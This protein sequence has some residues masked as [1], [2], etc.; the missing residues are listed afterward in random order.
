MRI[1]QNM[2]VH[3]VTRNLNDTRVKMDDLNEQI[4]SGKRIRKPSDDPTGAAVA[5]GLRARQ[6]RLEAQERGRGAAKDWLESTESNLADL[7]NTLIRVKELSVQAANT[8][9]DQA[10]RGHIA[11]ELDQILDHL[12]QVGNAR[13]GD[14]FLFAGDRTDTPPFTRAPGPAGATYNGTTNGVAMRV[15]A[16]VVIDV[17]IT[18]DRLLSVFSAIGALSTDLQTPGQEIDPVRLQAIEDAHDDVLSARASTGAKMNRLEALGE[19]AAEEGLAIAG[20]LSEVEDTDFVEAVL[21][22]QT[23]Q[24]VYQAALATGAKVIQPSLLDFLR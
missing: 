16:G 9:L 4:T 6:A 23:R 10:A 1:T 22:F 8:T 14:R 18:G 21:D 19:R 5:L 20:H 12:V 11:A 7:S 3:S 24:T 17:G 13:I 15:D 2:L